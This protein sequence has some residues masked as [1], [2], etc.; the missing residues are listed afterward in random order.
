MTK[1]E[2]FVTARHCLQSLWKVGVAGQR[3]RDASVKG[4]VLRFKECAEEKNCTLIRYN[5]LAA[6]RRVYDIVSDAKRRGTANI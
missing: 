1:D 3:Q 6:I 2:R 4:L 5:I